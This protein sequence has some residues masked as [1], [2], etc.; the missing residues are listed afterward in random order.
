MYCQALLPREDLPKPI[1]SDANSGAEAVETNLY[2]I[3]VAFHV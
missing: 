3:S 2:S 1:P